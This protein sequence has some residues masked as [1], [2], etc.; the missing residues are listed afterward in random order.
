M[1]PNSDTQDIVDNTATE[2]TG[3]QRQEPEDQPEGGEGQPTPAEG[4]GN[5]DTPD[6]PKEEPKPKNRAQERIQQLARDKAELAAKVAEY[7]AKQNAPTQTQDEPVLED[8]EDYNEWQKALRQYDREQIKK[9]MLAEMGQKETQKS[10]NQRQAEFEAAMVELQD[11][12]VD[13]QA[14]TQKLETLPPLPIDLHQFGLSAKETLTLAAKLINDDELWLDISQ[15]NPVQAARRIGQEIDKQPSKSAAPKIP[16]APK[17]IKPTSANA[18]VK[19]DYFS[20][21]DDEIMKGL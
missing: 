20:Q 2:N 19:R 1:D 9:E 10:Q 5:G 12:G 14:L 21:S 11:E 15:M 16:N 13:A 4:E 8:F 17:P 7:E 3:E 6:L 18:P